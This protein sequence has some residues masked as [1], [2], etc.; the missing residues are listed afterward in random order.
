[1]NCLSCYEAL[2]LTAIFT[3]PQVDKAYEYLVEYAD[4]QEQDVRF[5]INCMNGN[6]GIYLR[7]KHVTQ[8]ASE[9]SVS[10]DPVFTDTAGNN[11]DN[12]FNFYILQFPPLARSA[13]HKK[14]K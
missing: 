2:Q 7:E 11:N 1:M 5:S 4:V 13:A 10:V 6:R 12:K 14:T 8:R 3:T 9:F